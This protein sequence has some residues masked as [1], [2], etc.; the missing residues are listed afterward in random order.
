M[1]EEIVVDQTTPVKDGFL[2]QLTRM[3]V[4]ILRWLC[5]RNRTC[6]DRYV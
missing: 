3:P 5:V 2:Q 1:L 6:T 4:G